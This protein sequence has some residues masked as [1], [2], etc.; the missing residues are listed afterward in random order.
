MAKKGKVVVLLEESELKR[1]V[2]I[3]DRARIITEADRIVLT[4]KEGIK[5]IVFNENSFK[6]EMYR[7]IEFEMCF[8]FGGKDY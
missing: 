6:V 2:F 4:N 5:T 1:I 7:L 8:E 3:R